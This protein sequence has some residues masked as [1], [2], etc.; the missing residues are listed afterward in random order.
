MD[1]PVSI[2]DLPSLNPGEEE[3][4]GTTSVG[5]GL[6]GRSTEYTVAQE[7]EPTDYMR[8]PVGFQASNLEQPF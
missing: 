3:S 7:V 6:S 4:L 1:Q 2:S 5:W 8:S